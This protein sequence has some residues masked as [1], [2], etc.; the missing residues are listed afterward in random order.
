MNKNMKRGMCLLL[1]SALVLTSFV[2]VIAGNI[3]PHERWGNA[4]ID[5]VDAADN[6]EIT[7]W[8]YGVEYGSNITYNGDG[9]FSV[10]TE[11]DDETDTTCKYG[12]VNGDTIFYMI[13]NTGDGK[14][15]LIANEVSTFDSGASENA[16][17]NFATTGQPDMNIK[18]NEI[19]LQPGDAGN[20]YVYLYVPVG[21]TLAEWTLETHAGVIGTLD[22]LTT[23]AHP[24]D[25]ELLYVDLGGVPLGTGPGHLMLSWQASGGIANNALITLDRVEYGNQDTSP[26]NTTHVDYPGVPGAGEG[27]VRVTKGVDTDDSSVDFTI[28][29]ET[30]RPVTLTTGST[31]NGSVT[32]PGE[33]T[34]NYLQYELVAIEATADANYHFVNWT[35]DVGTI[36]D[37]NA[38]STTINMTASYSITANFA[39]NT[40]TLTTTS[41]VGGNVT[42]PGEGT[43]TYDYGTV[44]NITATPD[45][46]Y[47]FVNWTGDVGT[48]ADVNAASTTINMTGDYTIQANF[49]PDAVL[50]TVTGIWVEKS[51]ADLIVHWD[52]VGAPGYNVYHSA[53]KYA[54][55]PWTLVGDNVATNYFTHAGALGGEDYYYVRA[56]DGEAEGNMSGMGYCVDVEFIYHSASQQRYYTSVP[57]GFPDMNGDA[58]LTASDLVIHIE[59]GTGDGTN[60]KISRIGKWDATIGGYSENFYYQETFG[61]NGWTGGTDFTIAPGDGIVFFVES[62]FTWQ[63]NATDTQDDI[64]FIYHSAAQQRYY[65]SVPY[66]VM[67]YNGDGSLT[68]SDLVEA[69]EGGTGD[70]TNTK[71]SRIGKW[72]ATIGGYSENFYYQ[73]TFGGN[74]WTGGSDFT[75]APGDGIVF[76]VESDFTWNPIL[77]IPPQP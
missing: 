35:G 57:A 14:P 39:I 1:I 48:I 40:H 67:D 56:T 16:N 75:I 53:D 61:G 68:A 63:V 24:T 6:L 31:A 36:T 44:V 23:A 58:S 26:E 60:T 73:E 5:G 9:S 13:D 10:F 54:V 43:F 19:V 29:S 32:T 49:D 34:F 41:T 64:G 70:G 37:V 71:I 33:G 7:S 47:H 3:L 30:G 18:I 62:T 45:T 11:G 22:V 50:N 25:G 20:Q 2:G 8:I 55:M 66:T 69:I 74:G 42:D 46:D 17:L 65:L 12:G 4:D 52:D 59:G 72:D 38:A 51:G 28:A 76:F 77:I 27:L 15:D 21:I